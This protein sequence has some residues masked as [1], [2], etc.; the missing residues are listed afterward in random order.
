MMPARRLPTRWDSPI[1]GPCQLVALCTVAKF[2]HADRRERA[3]YSSVRLFFCEGQAGRVPNDQWL[4]VP[5]PRKETPAE[6]GASLATL[7]QAV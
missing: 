4:N 5:L 6:A 1:G 2:I 7:I 3:I